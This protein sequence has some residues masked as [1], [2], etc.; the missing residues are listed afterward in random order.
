MTKFLASAMVIA[1]ALALFFGVTFYGG[2]DPDVAAPMYL[3]GLFGALLWAA[4]LLFSQATWKSSPMHWPV[5]A[6][7]TYAFVRYFTS[8]VEYDARVELLHVL[9]CVL[10]YFT[11]CQFYRPTDRTIFFVTLLVLVSV[12]VVLALWQ[13]SS[14]TDLVYFWKE[15]WSR[16]ENYRGRGAG[17]YICPNNLAGFLEM[18]LGLILARGLLMHRGKSSVEAFAVQRLLIVYVALMAVVGIGVSLSRGGWV[19]TIAGLFML[20][21]WS[22]WRTHFHWGRLA[23]FALALGVLGLVVWKLAPARFQVFF[24]AKDAAT[25]T[26]TTG[27]ADSTLNSRLPLWKGTLELIREQPVFGTGAGS[28]QWHFL[29]HK[30][31]NVPT[32][33]EYTHNDY[34]NLLSDYGAVG[35]LLMLWVFV[36]FFQQAAKT[37][38]ARSPSEERSFA[39]GAVVGVAAILVHSLL[40][41]NLHIPAN[42]FLLALVMGSTA[43]IE[44]PDKQ[45]ARAPLS[46][47]RRR[48]L[49]GAL[50]VAVVVLGWQ[51][52]RTALAARETRRGNDAKFLYIAEP[53]IARAHYQRA[54]ELDARFP[55]PHWK[56]GD[57]Y[58][59]QAQ[60]LL[61]KDK[62][63]RRLELLAQARQSYAEALRLNPYLT[64]VLLRAAR[65][66][67]MAGEDEQALKKYLSAVELEPNSSLNH[68]NLGMFYR[69][70]DREEEALRHYEKALTLNH[71]QDQSLVDVV[72]ELRDAVKLKQAPKP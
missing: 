9:L 8:P 72:L 16:P 33:P 55:T 1:M 19:A 25:G 65:A 70:R 61:G 5:L 69:D 49:G 60:W 66:D 34:L 10:A 3:C 42:A 31:H 7:G 23:A 47:G 50:V 13:F 21:V 2:V 26:M 24:T 15:S 4:K 35:F 53:D 29:K 37:S 11:A 54:V 39:V 58:R 27:V 56:L 48:A 20:L 38:D 57:T 12:Q 45:F 6:F 14:K 18:V 40:D 68:R 32:H 43:A 67:E 17:S 36:A 63:A 44:D 62:K 51:F 59:S 71:A 46:D 30:P 28:W 41:F 64:D 22:N 52:T